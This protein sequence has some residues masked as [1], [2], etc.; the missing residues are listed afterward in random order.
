MFVLSWLLKRFESA[1]LHAKFQ[2]QTIYFLV[3]FVLTS[4]ALLS[5]NLI[6]RLLGPHQKKCY[7]VGQPT[8]PINR[9]K[10]QNIFDLYSNNS[11]ECLA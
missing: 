5:C 3:V 6:A 11:R 7:E 1:A 8:R 2:L 9:L 10:H 4:L